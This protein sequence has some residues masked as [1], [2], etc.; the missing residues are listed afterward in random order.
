LGSDDGGKLWINDEFV[1]GENIPRA[2]QRD[3]DSPMA[4]LR[5]GWNKILV[6]ITQTGG[7]WGL[8]FRIYDP[9]NSLRY[10]MRPEG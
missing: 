9:D 4:F 7:A 5:A 1:W 6:K 3:E 8:Y 10:S 2:A